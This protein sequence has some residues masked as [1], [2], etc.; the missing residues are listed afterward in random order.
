VLP[1]MLAHIVD[2]LSL[3]MPENLELTV[4]GPQVALS[5]PG[6]GR[7]VVA[8]ETPGVPTEVDRAGLAA[9]AT[10]MLTDLQDLVVT[11]LRTP[12]PL[13][14]NGQVTH[15]V[16]ELLGTSLEMRFATRGDAPGVVITLRAYS[17]PEN[18]PPVVI[19][20]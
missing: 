11:H 12:W 14:E 16:A 13:A 7:R 18:L 4:A 17:V 3:I 9:A 19:A 1:D 20:G 6:G 15:P 10:H 2:Q 8:T 5:N